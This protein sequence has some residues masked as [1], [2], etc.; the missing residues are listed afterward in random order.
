MLET[1]TVADL[2][3]VELLCT[4]T[5]NA[6]PLHDVTLKD[7]LAANTPVAFLIATPKFCQ[8]AI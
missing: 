4:R 5:P 6:C 2:K 8:T 1:P 3:G 7:A